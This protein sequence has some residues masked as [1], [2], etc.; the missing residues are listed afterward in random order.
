MGEIGIS[1]IFHIYLIFIFYNQK[2]VT[3]KKI[4]DRPPISIVVQ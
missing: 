2:T 4:S 1:P 3:F